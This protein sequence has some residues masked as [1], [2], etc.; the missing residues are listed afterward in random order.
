MDEILDKLECGNFDR[1]NQKS[2]L[3][4]RVRKYIKQLEQE[5]KKIKQCI[6]ILKEQIGV[7]NKNTCKINCEGNQEIKEFYILCQYCNAPN[8][9]KDQYELINEALRYE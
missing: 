8:L 2:N 7:Y 1:P 3:I 5:N 6:K 4:L 9:T